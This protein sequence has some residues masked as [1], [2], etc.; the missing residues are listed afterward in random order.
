MSNAL[1]I[2]ASG[3]TADSTMLSITANNLANAQTLGT[4]TSRAYASESVVLQALPAQQGI[5]QGV[6]VAGIVTDPAPGAVTYDPAS[7]FA[8]A[9]GDVVGTNV[10]MADQMANMLEASTAY[11]ANVT[12]FNAAK[13]VDQR[14][15]TV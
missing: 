14:A 4:A 6:E 10:S 13:A 7:P 2:A 1:G 5:G 9:Q 15:L 12:A 11:S 8:N 3:L